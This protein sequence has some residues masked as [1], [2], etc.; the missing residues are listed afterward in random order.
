MS[1]IES[2]TEILFE[3]IEKEFD[4]PIEDKSLNSLMLFQVNFDD[5]RKVLDFLITNQKKQQFLIQ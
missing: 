2:R 4:L 3:Q 5:L 1:Y